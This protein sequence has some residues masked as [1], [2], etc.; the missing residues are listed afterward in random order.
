L[1]SQDYK[2]K[3]AVNPKLIISD[4]YPFSKKIRETR[5]SAIKRKAG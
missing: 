1:I 5:L 4:F 3:V 2:A